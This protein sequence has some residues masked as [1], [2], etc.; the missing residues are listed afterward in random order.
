M[1]IFLAKIDM[2]ITSFDTLLLSVTEIAFPICNDVRNDNKFKPNKH[3]DN[4]QTSTPY[5]SI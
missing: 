1:F 4:I 2:E 3:R 5:N